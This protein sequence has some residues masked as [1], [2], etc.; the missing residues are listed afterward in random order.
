M[1]VVVNNPQPAESNNSNFLIGIVLLVVLALLFV[2]YVL[3]RM[4]NT[5][6]GGSQVNVPGKIDVNVQTPNK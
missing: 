1:P 5:G 3:P 4:G 2:F 6:L